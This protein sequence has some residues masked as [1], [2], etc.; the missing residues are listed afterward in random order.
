MLRTRTLAYL[1]TLGFSF[2]AVAAYAPSEA[3]ADSRVARAKKKKKKKKKKAKKGGDGTSAKA[4]IKLTAEQKK[5]RAELLGPF[6]WGMSKDEVLKALSK[7]LD[8][9]YAEKIADTTDVYKQD[10]LRKEKSKE[11]KRVKKSWVAFET[12]KKSG[13]DVS[14]VDQEFARGVDEAMLEYWENQGGK[15]QRRFFF[16]DDGELYKMFVQIDTAQFPEDQRDFA[17]FGGLMKT[18]LGD[19]A[20]GD[21]SIQSTEDIWVRALDKGKTFDAFCLVMGDPARMK[22]VYADRKER[23]KIEVKG[24]SITNSIQEDP[25]GSTPNLDDNKD[26]V[27]DII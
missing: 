9:R 8:E 19:S 22:A 26:A 11:I 15:N 6:T 16:F 10:K 12:D 4:A 3:D 25:D 21:L 24:N 18:R 13:W 7:Q 1:L 20:V 14:I 17:Y 27:K 5:A 23:V 2:G